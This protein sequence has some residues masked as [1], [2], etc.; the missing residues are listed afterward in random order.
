MARY[1]KRPVTIE[2]FCLGQDPIPDWFMDKVSSNDIV[3][4]GP[5]GRLDCC[6]IRTLEGVMQGEHGDW[7]IQGVAGEIYACK[8]AIFAQTYEVVDG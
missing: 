7:I 3:L 8:A 6:Q 1:R 5:S 4:H 2:A